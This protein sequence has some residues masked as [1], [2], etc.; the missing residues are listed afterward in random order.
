MT[1]HTKTLKAWASCLLC[2]ALHHTPVAA[3]PVWHCSRSD[4]QIADMSDN[5]T[6]A[7]LGTDREVI[8]ISLRDLYSVYKGEVVR[9]SGGLPL[10]ACVM[11]QQTALTSQVLKSIGASTPAIRSLT[12]VN[13]ISTKNIHLVADETAM[14]ACISKNHPAVGYLPSATHIETVGPCF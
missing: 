2:I 3:D 7:A 1:K 11:S 12:K 10:S 4:V 8:R 14:L 9:M 13:S 6:L 5:F